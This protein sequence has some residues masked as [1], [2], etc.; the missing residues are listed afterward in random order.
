LSSQPTND[1][2]QDGYLNGRVSL[3]Q[4][5]R[6][7]RAG[8]DPVF[9]A[10]SCPAHPG[11]TVLELG[12][13]VG[14]ASA[15]LQARVDGL[16]I[17]GIEVQ[18]PLA[19]LARRNLPSADIHTGNLVD[20]PVPLR[21]QSFDQVIANP[22][23]FLRTHGTAAPDPIREGSMGEATPLSI[24]IDVARRR[25]KPRG[26]LT[27]IHRADRLGHVLGHMQEC[28]GSLQVLALHPRAGRDASLI[29]IRARKLGRSP[30][31]ILAPVI[32]HALP[33]HQSDEPDYA[34]EINEVLR[35]GM[36]M[37][38]FS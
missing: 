15:C 21:D 12:C 11:D 30:T 17:S 16:T 14:A 25:L 2:T 1:L 27:M 8:V 34:P 18:P 3:W 36:A 26:W 29:L 5:A 10:A 37:P 28:F 32:L 38:G 22:P 33:E 7:Y 31:R 13:G 20:M 4:P 9:L 23:Y 24:W 35:D 6:G 19:D